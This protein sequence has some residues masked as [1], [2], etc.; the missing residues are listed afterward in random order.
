[1]SLKANKQSDIRKTWG[2]NSS[3]KPEL[4]LIKLQLDSYNWFLT[5]GI[6]EVLNEISPIEDFT[7]KNWLLE[8]GETTKMLG[9]I[10][11]STKYA[12]LVGDVGQLMVREWVDVIARKGGAAGASQ[13]AILDTLRKNVGT[14][15][16]GLK[17]ST[18]AIQPTALIDGM[19]LYCSLFC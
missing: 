13:I 15:I 7:G 4:D 1:M 12:E 19:G 8:L 18:I 16:L 2:K 5:E 14:G 9:E 11:A 3:I 6:K 17:L 10:A